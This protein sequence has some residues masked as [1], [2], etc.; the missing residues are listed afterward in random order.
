MK[1]LR[2][3]LK[4]RYYLFHQ[5]K[6]IKKKTTYPNTFLNQDENRVS[7]TSRKTEMQLFERTGWEEGEEQKKELLATRFNT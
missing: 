7:N 5:P 1:I 6:H 2:K 4:I 3:T